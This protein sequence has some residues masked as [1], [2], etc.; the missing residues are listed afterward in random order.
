MKITNLL[1]MIAKNIFFFLI[2]AIIGVLIVIKFVLP[3]VFET[4]IVD[5]TPGEVIVGAIALVPIFFI[6]YGALGVIVGG[7]GLII[8]YNILRVI[9]KKR[10]KKRNIVG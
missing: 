1:K 5:A 3:K 4:S 7:F 6:I 8:I 2:G 10:R 9:L